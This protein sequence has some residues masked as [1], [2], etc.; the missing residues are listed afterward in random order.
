MAF[1]SVRPSVVRLFF[2]SVTRW[3]RDLTNQAKIARSSPSHS[4]IILVFGKEVRLEINTKSSRATASNQAEL[5]KSGNFAA[6]PAHRLT[7][8]SQGRSV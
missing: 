2:P 6:D 3:Y 8:H 5:G 1:P 4:P 7:V